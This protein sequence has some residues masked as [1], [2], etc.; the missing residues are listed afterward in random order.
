MAEKKVT[1]SEQT[2]LKEKFEKGEIS[3]DYFIRKTREF[4]RQS[5]ENENVELR[6]EI[7]RLQEVVNDLKVKLDNVE[8]C[9]SN[10][11]VGNKTSE[12]KKV[13]KE[14]KKPVN[15]YT[16]YEK[17]KEYLKDNLLV[18]DI[19]KYGTSD[20]L[21]TCI[22]IRTTYEQR[23]YPHFYS[24]ISD[25]MAGNVFGARKLLDDNGNLVINYEKSIVNGEEKERIIEDLADKLYSCELGKSSFEAVPFLL[26][27]ADRNDCSLYADNFDWFFKEQDMYLNEL[28]GIS[29][30]DTDNDSDE[31]T[32][33]EFDFDKDFEDESEDT[34]EE[35]K[36]D[37]DDIAV[38]SFDAL[39]DIIGAYGLLRHLLY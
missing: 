1:K 9:K 11:T 25:A 38:A 13:T 30:K 8:K 4:A 39:L 7:E 33:D 34:E 15:T 20:R 36:V 14:V 37:S 27:V 31:E 32:Q 26:R 29:N 5:K 35:D 21:M 28:E 2:I 19:L 3:L 6:G 16:T 10:T 18:V 12:N 23:P 22:I 17:L 24:D